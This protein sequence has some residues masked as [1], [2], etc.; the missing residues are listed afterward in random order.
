VVAGYIFKVESYGVIVKFREALTALVPRPNV[1]DRFVSNPEGLFVVG[2]S[3]RCVIQRVDLARERVIATFKS[4]VVTPSSGILSFLKA[5]L[6]EIRLTSQLL[7]ASENKTLPAWKN[8]TLGSVVSATVSSVESYGVVLTASDMTTMMLCRG[9]SKEGA[10]VGQEVKVLIL[11]VDFTNRV[12]DV[13]LDK[14]LIAT[15]TAPVGAPLEKSKKNKKDPVLSVKDSLAVKGSTLKGRIELVQKEGKYLVVSLSKS[16][17]AYVMISDYHCPT[18]DASEYA[19]HQEL[20]LRVECPSSQNGEASEN[21]H[22]SVAILSVYKEDKGAQKREG[23]SESNQKS[24]GDKGAKDP[25]VLKKSFLDS[26]RL[27]AVLQWRVV[28]VSPVEVLVKPD[29]L[30]VMDLTVKASIHLTGTVDQLTASDNFKKALSAAPIRDQGA[31]VEVLPGHPFHHIAVGAKIVARVIQFRNSN[32]NSMP[33][34]G[35][36]KKEVEQQDKDKDSMII[37]LSL[38]GLGLGA[39]DDTSGSKKRKGGDDDRFTPMLQLFGKNAVQTNGLYAGCITKMEDTSCIVALSPYISS[40]L[41]FMDVSNDEQMVKTFMTRGYIGQRLVVQV[42]AFSFDTKDKDKRKPK[43]VTISRV[44]AEKHI[45]GEVTLSLSGVSG[46]AITAGKSKAT[47]LEPGSLITGILDLKSR[48]PRVSRPPALLIS[49]GDGRVGRVCLTELS[50]PS[51]WKDCS[52]MLAA[53]S[54]SS[55]ALQLPDGRKHGSIV[56]C[57]VLSIPTPSSS[58]SSNEGDVVELSLRSSRVTCKNKKESLLPDPIPSEGSI[59]Q[60]FVANC[61]EKGKGCFLRLTH[62]ITGQVLMKDLSDEV[63]LICFLNSNYILT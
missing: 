46:T 48:Y 25:I 23:S 1:A 36:G 24:V 18:I 13:T 55:K 62:A 45:T 54:S 19:E 26:L 49:L 37:Y 9:A 57:R 5:W 20:S 61:S 12:L 35:K 33:A 40:R 14:E 50:D 47:K 44:G 52:A 41:N 28:S 11:D 3:V 60:A 17:I 16:A 34:K 58:S 30:E 6:L 53:P 27:G 43:G 7:A 63:S 31:K 38:E 2:D 21:F 32:T 15:I 22:S 39:D 42:T 8:F 56:Q 29:Y 51:E 4:A 59:L 10:K